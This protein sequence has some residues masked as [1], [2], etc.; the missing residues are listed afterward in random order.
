MASFGLGS[1]EPSFD[2]L[3]EASSAHSVDPGTSFDSAWAFVASSHKCPVAVA[4]VLTSCPV[5]A[6]VADT[7]S[8]VETA[9]MAAGCH[10]VVVAY[11]AADAFVV[12][13]SAAVVAYDTAAVVDTAAAVED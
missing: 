4:W 10:R 3:V 13:A 2:H 11:I 6:A 1:E 5:A 7:A 9:H 12:A 8:A